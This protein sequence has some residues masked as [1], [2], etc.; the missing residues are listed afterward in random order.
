MAL[1]LPDGATIAIAT[2]YGSVK[3]V[4]AVTNA[5]PAVA[6]STAHGLSNGALIE[7]TSGWNELNG[8]VQ[9]VAGQTA[10]TFN[11]DGLDS[12]SLTLYPAGSGG[13]SVRE[14]TT[15]QQIQ[16]IIGLSTS[17]GEQQYTAVNL[18][19][20][21]YEINLPTF[22]S[23]QSLE[24][25]IAY[26]QTL[27]GYIALKAASRTRSARAIRLTLADGSF[28]LYNGIISLNETPNMSKGNVMTVTATISLQGK[29][30]SYAS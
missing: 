9:R 10:G 19:E 15:F 4:T 16:Q 26:D 6:S 28:F 25:E 23:A 7:V 20:N 29:P 27:P 11:Y 13:G 30:V 3:T 14:I 22:T 18:L 1:K 17:G 21:N 24:L 12:T 8:T 2:A 5:N